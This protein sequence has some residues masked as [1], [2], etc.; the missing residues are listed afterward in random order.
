MDSIEIDLL[1]YREQ[2]IEKLKAKEFDILVIGGGITGAGIAR[3]AV[4][5][6]Y[7]VALIEKN[8][9]GFG[10]SS[11]SSKIVHAGIRYLGQREFRLVREGSVER[12]KLL[13]MA[14]HLTYPIKFLLPMYS[15]TKYPKSRILE[16]N[17]SASVA[18]IF[19]SFVLFSRFI[20]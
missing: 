20:V 3:D 11:G 2:T 1:N 5:R 17:F 16:T 18:K 15:D 7:S 4:L 9:F 12:K 10:T 19:N 8:D 6:G 13:E 14:P